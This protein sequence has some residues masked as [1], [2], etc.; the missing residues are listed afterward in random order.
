M[1]ASSPT[2]LDTSLRLAQTT[3]ERPSLVEAATSIAA[4]PY[5]IRAPPDKLACFADRD[6]PA[7]PRSRH[8]KPGV[9]GRHGRPRSGNWRW[10]RAASPARSFDDRAAAGG[11][12]VAFSSTRTSQMDDA[13][14]TIMT[15]AEA[16]KAL[17]NGEVRSDVAFQNDVNRLLA[18]IDD[19]WEPSPARPFSA[20][21]SSSVSG[22][23]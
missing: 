8:P 3:E 14:F 6:A 15:V 9:P 2:R 1:A 12:S 5:R 21:L 19:L 13:G 4:G 16:R 23:S 18:S 11:M 17:T 7:C 20:L 22:T 10:G